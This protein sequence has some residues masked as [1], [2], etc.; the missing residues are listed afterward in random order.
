MVTSAEER[1]RT[2]PIPLWRAATL[3]RCATLL[4]LAAYAPAGAIGGEIGSNPPRIQPRRNESAPPA[5]A[6]AG[7]QAD[8]DEESESEEERRDER[9]RKEQAGR[10]PQPAEAPRELGTPSLVRLRVAAAPGRTCTGVLAAANASAVL[11]LTSARCL[12][13]G[14]AEPPGGVTLSFEGMAPVPAPIVRFAPPYSA[15]VRAGRAPPPGTDLAAALATT[16]APNEAAPLF[17]LEADAP[18]LEQLRSRGL[19][20]LGFGARGA[21]G[22]PARL[23]GAGKRLSV[24]PRSGRCEAGDAGGA[25]TAFIPPE[26]FLLGLASPPGKGSACELAQPAAE[27]GLRAFVSSLQP[28]LGLAV[29]ACRRAAATGHVTCRDLER[30]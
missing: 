23:E 1:C 21:R 18:T 11:V 15:A 19:A 28:L 20:L 26:T 10:G 9:R 24:R 4:L 2:S 17:L 30:P 29:K 12:G 22:R 6:G 25:I 3:R 14:A 5:R 7:E 27:P 16:V 8:G 13:A